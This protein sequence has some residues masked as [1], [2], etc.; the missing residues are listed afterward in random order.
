M[1]VYLA[2]TSKEMHM[3]PDMM[4]CPILAIMQE[5]SNDVVIMWWTYHLISR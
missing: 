3:D 2:W 4:V 5:Y 1:H